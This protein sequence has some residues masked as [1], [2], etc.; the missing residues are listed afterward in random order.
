MARGFMNGVIAGGLIGAAVGM[1][2]LPQIK[3]NQGMKAMMG[4]TRKVQ[5]KAGKILKGVEDF[6]D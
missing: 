2:L 5:G 4:R 3:Q 6:L 1:F